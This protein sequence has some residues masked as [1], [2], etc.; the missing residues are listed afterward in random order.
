VQRKVTKMPNVRAN[1]ITIEYEEFGRRGATPLLMI[2]GLGCQMVMWD[3]RACKELADRGFRVIRYDNRDVGLST[4][5]ND[6][7]PDPAPLIF[8]LLQGKS[9][10]PPYTLDDMA[11]D[12]AELLQT[13]GIPSAHIVGASMG[14]MIAQL[15]AIDHPDQVLTLT[16]IM[17]TTGNPDLP[18]PKP[19]V[20]AVLLQPSPTE[21]QAAIEHELRV[22]RTIA[23]TAFAFDEVRMRELVALSYDR[24]PD[25]TGTARQ[26][27]AIMTAPSRK[28]ALRSVTKP[29]LVIHGDADPL[30]PLAGGFDTAEAIPGAKML[31][32]EG[33][34]HELPEGAWPRV[35]GGIVELTRRVG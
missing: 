30:A 11:E 26:L 12:A 14:G 31:V 21:R 33:M 23:G 27:L 13:L 29:S 34:G 18:Q 7:C 5:F 6:R 35:I 1:G 10:D 15:L 17:S 2:M 28:D 19:E 20:M 3:E 9:I 24:D 32:I 16:S 22:W 8:D 25:A 4:K